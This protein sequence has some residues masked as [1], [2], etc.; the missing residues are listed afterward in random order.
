M[1][2]IMLTDFVGGQWVYRC[3][4]RLKLPLSEARRLFF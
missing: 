2:D 1:L 3:V 4:P